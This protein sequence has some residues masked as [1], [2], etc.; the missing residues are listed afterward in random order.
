MKTKFLVFADLHVD[1]MH[2]S[3]K[4][5]EQILA[6]AKEKKVDYIIHLGDVMYP[7][8]D[9]VR[10]HAPQ[11]FERR[12]EAWFLCER[13]GEKAAIRQMLNDSG[14]KVYGVLGNHDMDACDK[15]TACRYWNMPA[16]H[17]TF[18]EGGVRFIALDS[19]FIRTED[20]DEDFAY[21]N[22]RHSPWQQLHFIPDE[23]LEWLEKTLFASKEPCVLL[24]HAALGDDQLCVQNRDRVWDIV[25]R[26]N[27]NGRRV[28]AAFNGHNHADGV[29]M[30]C[31]VPFISINS[32]SNLWMGETWRTTRFSQQISQDYPHIGCTAP[33]RDALYAVITITDEELAMEGVTSE[34]V[35]LSPQQVGLPRQMYCHEPV[36]MTRS[37]RFELRRK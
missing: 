5:M 10:R 12:G 13:D 34:Y 36:P 26:A 9:Y 23:Q 32:A 8:A 17:Y 21:C 3:V 11:D 33:Y 18:T 35:G 22:Y 20:G 1:I 25:R 2:D 6:A 15:S 4:R 16:P 30:R 28:I 31:G 37:R 27:E 29:T 7:E 19:Q 14:L 24:S